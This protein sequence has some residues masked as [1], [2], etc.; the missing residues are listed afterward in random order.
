MQGSVAALKG[1]GGGSMLEA[2][3][4]WVTCSSTRGLNIYLFVTQGSL[5]PTAEGIVVRRRGSIVT[6]HRRISVLRITH[7]AE[8]KISFFFFDNCCFPFN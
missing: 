6:L 1:G 3:K 5:F 8:K 2:H 7:T 4:V